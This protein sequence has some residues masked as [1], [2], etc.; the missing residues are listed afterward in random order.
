MYPY[1][2][3]VLITTYNH[4]KYLAEAIESILLQKVN[5]PFEI[6][7]ADDSSTDATPK[8]ALSYQKKHPEI[9]IIPSHKNLGITKNLHHS[10]TQ[11]TGEFIAILEGDDY[12]ISPHKL[13]RQ[14]EFLEKHPSLSMCFNG[15]LILDKENLYREHHTGLQ[16]KN[17]FVSTQELVLSNIIG[18]F[19][20]C[21]Y[22]HDII[23]KLPVEIYEVFTVDWMFNLACSEFGLLGRIP[24]QMTAY[25]IQGQGVWSSTSERTQI[26]KT[27]NIIPT[28]DALLKHKYTN[29]FKRT[30]KKLKEALANIDPTFLTKLKRIYKKIIKKVLNCYVI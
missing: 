3:S 19:S 17:N 20:A 18:N 25:R 21:M 7:I 6:L 26:L 23:K 4:E 13:Q 9:K 10:L 14:V 24:T 15:I 5:F 22:R 29:E 8:I 11:C 16:C 30:T 2:L 12:W 27:L 28:Y 1:K